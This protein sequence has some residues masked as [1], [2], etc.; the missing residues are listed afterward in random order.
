MLKQQLFRASIL[1]F[2]HATTDPKNEVEYIE[3]G[4]LVIEGERI[5]AT[6]DFASVHQQ[7]S[8]AQ[9]NDYRGKWI[10]PGFIDSHLHY[11]QTEMI[12]C[13]GSQLLTWLENFTF[14]TEQKFADDDYARKIA[15]VFLNQL[16]KNGTTTGLVFSSVHKSAT[17]ILFD[18]ANEMK[19]AL[20]TG[21]VCM[22]RNC[23]EFLRDTADS[24]HQESAQLIEKWHGK[25]R[26]YYALT[27]RF[28][29]TSSDHQL[30]ALA[31]LAAQ[32]PDVFIQTHLS[33]NL[34]EVE[35]VKSLFP[36]AKGYL[37]VYDK[38]NLVRE[39]AT[40]GHCLHLTDEEWQRMAQAK[41]TIAFCPTSN[42][43]L[44]SGLFDMARAKQEKIHV[45]LGTD[46]GGGTGF[47]MLRTYGE[48]YKVCQLKNYPLAPME[49]L[50]MMTQGAA[51]AHKLE[52]SV[53]NLN[54]GTHA[55]FVVLEPQ[56]D[57]LTRLRLN[58][59]CS[60]E[61]MVFAMSML[62]D[63]RAT[64]ETWVAGT[65]RYSKEKE[66]ADAMA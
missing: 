44:G 21:K 7:Y 38:Y 61:D 16:L 34:E 28:A 10:V 22:D 25:G 51:V 49:G 13:Y 4:A 26:N 53:G 37:D 14:P 1:H 27:P 62:A 30:G 60:A 19:M 55:D 35:W 31:E 52:T 3:D 40:F 32:F 24:A 48:A 2:P 18:V 50:Y 54:P 9:V 8:T 33:E 59:S 65:K 36:H 42:L 41:A 39:R 43:F 6:G 64:F 12:G 20:V 29:P 23:P 15:E 5:L 45:T 57:E 11:P 58:R 46:V 47:N 63:D 17:D 56:F 66:F